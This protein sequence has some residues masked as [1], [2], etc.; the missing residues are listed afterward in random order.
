MTENNQSS[1]RA[2][3]SHQVDRPKIEQI[4]EKMS[5]PVSAAARAITESLINNAG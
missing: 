2:Q 1:R 5:F 3:A 4:C